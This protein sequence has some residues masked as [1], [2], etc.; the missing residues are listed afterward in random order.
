MKV[1]RKGGA[2]Q[3]QQLKWVKSGTAVQFIKVF[4]G[5]YTLKEIFMV[6]DMGSYDSD[7]KNHIGKIGVTSLVSGRLSFVNPQ[8][9][10]IEINAEV[11]IN[12][13]ET[14]K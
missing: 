8:R 1:I 11:I 4:N 2:R 3:C 6:M 7:Y 14:K 5:K 10:V 9:E 13:S 12:G